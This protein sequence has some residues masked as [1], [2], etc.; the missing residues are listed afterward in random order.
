MGVLLLVN[1]GPFESASR[2]VSSSF[3]LF[4]ILVLVVESDLFSVLAVRYDRMAA[5]SKTDSP[6]LAANGKM[7]S[8]ALSAPKNES[9][10]ASPVLP[11]KQP[12]RS[13]SRE[14]SSFR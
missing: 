10:A 11:P 13:E 12:R 2:D 3:S 4:L 8:P 5:K 6:A 9:P 7:E 1:Q 14:E